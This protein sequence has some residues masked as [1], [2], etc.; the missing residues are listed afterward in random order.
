MK[1]LT[2]IV[3]C[4]N[5]EKF[6]LK[7]LESIFIQKNQKDF[8]DVFIIDDG[9]TDN[10]RRIVKNFVDSKKLKNFFL[11]EKENGNWGSVI[12]YAKNN[13]NLNSK[14]VTIL[15]AD[16]F[17]KED[18]FEVLENKMD[19]NYDLIFSGFFEIKKGNKIRKGYLTPQKGNKE[20]QKKYLRFPSLIPLCKFFKTSIFKKL[21]DL[22]EGVSYQDVILWNKFVDKANT[23]YYIK[24][25][26]GYY[27]NYREGASSTQPFDKKRINIIMQIINE[28]ISDDKYTNGYLVA[29]LMHLKKNTPKVLRKEI[30]LDKNNFKKIR[31]FKILWCFFGSRI[32]VKFIMYL[33]LFK[34][35]KK[36]YF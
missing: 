2:I 1:N 18:L 16:D 8:C 5:V 20:I 28:L 23:F 9:S 21:D 7:N 13:L 24:K 10:T 32:I 34:L 6:I 33:Y 3:P 11:I 15:D 36:G 35:F 29:L 17:F 27:L 22:R 26:Y 25:E 30:I 14:Y 31:K 4:Y 19:K 12:N